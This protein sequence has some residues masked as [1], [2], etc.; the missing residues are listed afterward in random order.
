MLIINNR[1]VYVLALFG[2]LGNPV[3]TCKA[4]NLEFVYGLRPVNV[5]VTRLGIFVLKNVVRH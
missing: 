5:H 4:M 3:E 1:S 2:I